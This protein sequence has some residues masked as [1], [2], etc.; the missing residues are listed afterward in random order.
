MLIAAVFTK[1]EDGNLWAAA[2][3]LCSDDKPASPTLESLAKLQTKHLHSSF[4]NHAT[5]TPQ[6]TSP[7]TVS[8][9][10]VLVAIRSFPAGSSGGLNGLHPQHVLDMVISQESGL[11]LLSAITLFVNGLLAGR[12]PHEVVSILFGGSLIA[13]QKKSGDI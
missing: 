2:L 7:L 11:E 10:V 4:I 3:I 5:A 1:I 8:E 13:L 9:E 6:L 12:C